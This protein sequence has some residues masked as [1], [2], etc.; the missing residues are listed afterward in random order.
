MVKMKNYKNGSIDIRYSV[1][2]IEN[3]HYIEAIFHDNGLLSLIPLFIWQHN[4]E[5]ITC[6]LCCAIQRFF[7]RE[8]SSHKRTTK[9]IILKMLVHLSSLLSLARVKWRFNERD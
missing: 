2:S 6:V 5:F 4:E 1:A 7:L 3:D 9:L 8:N